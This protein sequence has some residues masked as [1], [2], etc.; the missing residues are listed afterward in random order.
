MLKKQ[1]LFFFFLFF[2]QNSTYR[3]KTSQA[4]LPR[5]EVI[6]LPVIQIIHLCGMDSFRAVYFLSLLFP[7]F[8][9]AAQ[10]LLPALYANSQMGNWRRDA[11]LR[12]MPLSPN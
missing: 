1:T 12:A 6:H 7:S 5:V 2:P 8:I 4:L 10:S 9:P 11:S 3:G